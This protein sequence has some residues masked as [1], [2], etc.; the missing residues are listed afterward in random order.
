MKQ[1]FALFILIGLANSQ[2]ADLYKR[3]FHGEPKFDIDVL[4]YDINL[5]IN[6][7]EKSFYGKT[8]IEF[9]IKRSSVDTVRFDTE[10]FRVTRVF[11]DTS[12]LS[13][14]QQNGSLIIKPLSPLYKDEKRTYTIHYLSLIHI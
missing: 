2:T 12:S 3:P 4:H 13:F 6:D 9:L 5:K 14:Y 10:T 1:L 8:S 11:E 7:H